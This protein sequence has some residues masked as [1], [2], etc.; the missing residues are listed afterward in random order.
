MGGSGVLHEASKVADRHS[1][2]VPL[3]AAED[4]GVVMATFEWV[5]PIRARHNLY[6]PSIRDNRTR[7]TARRLA[8]VPAERCAEGTRGSIAD[9]LGHFGDGVLGPEPPFRDGHTPAQ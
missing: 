8:H 7:T 2:T 1:P 5:P 3:V 4:H 9:T 6:E